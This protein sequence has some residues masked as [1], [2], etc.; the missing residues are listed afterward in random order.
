M[1]YL[2]ILQKIPDFRHFYITGCHC[3]SRGISLHLAQNWLNG[4]GRN[5]DISGCLAQKF[6]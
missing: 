5:N 2:G 6:R 4:S 1:T 3:L